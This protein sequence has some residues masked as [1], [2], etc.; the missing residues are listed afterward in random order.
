MPKENE[1]FTSDTQPTPKYDF[2]NVNLVTGEGMQSKFQSE[3][4]MDAY[5]D[6]F[7]D[8]CDKRGID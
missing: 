1:Q 5:F 4:E 7:N 6:A 2:S 8:E 3:E